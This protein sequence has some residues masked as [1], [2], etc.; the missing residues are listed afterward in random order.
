M[1]APH[2]VEFRDRAVELARTGDKPVAVLARDLGISESCLSN[3]MAQ[4]DADDGGGA[5]RLS[6]AEKRGTRRARPA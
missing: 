5:D 3:W 1:P 6:T 2:L 4:A